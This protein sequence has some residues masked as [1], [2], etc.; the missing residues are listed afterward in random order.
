MRV[1]CISIFEFKNNSLNNYKRL[2]VRCEGR[3][4]LLP[5]LLLYDKFQ[6]L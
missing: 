1:Q 2:A 5:A 6:D 4:G 3:V